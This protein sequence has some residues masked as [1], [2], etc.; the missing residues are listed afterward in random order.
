MALIGPEGGFTANE[1]ALALRFGFSCVSL[2]PRTLKADTA[3]VVVTAIIQYG[4][5]DMSKMP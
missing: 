2:G 4:F 3:A 1:V 5:G